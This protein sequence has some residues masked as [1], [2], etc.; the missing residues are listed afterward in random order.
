LNTKKNV[1]FFNRRGM[2]TG[3]CK[4]PASA[5]VNKSFNFS[6]TNKLLFLFNVDKRTLIAAACFGG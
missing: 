6:F 1:V 5:P 3:E 2:Q 4:L